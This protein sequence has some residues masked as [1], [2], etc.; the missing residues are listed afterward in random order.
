M[1]MIPGLGKLKQKN[2]EHKASLCAPKKDTVSKVRQLTDWPT[3]QLNTQA[4]AKSKVKPLLTSHGLQNCIFGRQF[5][6]LNFSLVKGDYLIYD[7]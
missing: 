3:N 7:Y 2:E 1:P 4:N 5:V 6:E